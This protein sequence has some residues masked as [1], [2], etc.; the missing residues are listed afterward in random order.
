MLGLKSRFDEDEQR[1]A[2]NMDFDRK[3]LNHHNRDLYHAEVTDLV[4]R[5]NK[6]VPEGQPQL[7]V[8]DIKFHRAIGRWANQPYSVKGELLSEE[9]YKKHLNEVL[10]NEKD[11]ALVADIFKDPSWIEEK[12]IPNDPWAYQKATHAGTKN[13]A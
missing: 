11:L 9:E 4:S 7:Y 10:P 13:N 6:F 1:K 5:L 3:E 12:K 8:P 2:G